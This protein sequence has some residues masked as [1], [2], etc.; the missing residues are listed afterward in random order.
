MFLMQI[1]ES[2]V[3]KA[4]AVGRGTCLQMRDTQ[5]RLRRVREDGSW[6]EPEQDAFTQDTR[7]RTTHAP[8]SSSHPSSGNDTVLSG[9]RHIVFS[10]SIFTLALHMM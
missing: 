10:L 2:R 8:A 6:M 5:E 4:G 1:W 7:I 9:V 3:G